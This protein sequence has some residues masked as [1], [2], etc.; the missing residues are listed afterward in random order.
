MV[1][2]NERRAIQG[3]IFVVP[4]T[5]AGGHRRHFPWMFRGK[6]LRKWSERWSEKAEQEVADCR[7]RLELLSLV[8]LCES[9]IKR[10]NERKIARTFF[11][12]S[13][14]IKNPNRVGFL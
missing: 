13:L 10:L 1:F 3:R 6:L 4:K 12:V 11:F 14:I 7:Q 8:L 2:G 5:S 9:D